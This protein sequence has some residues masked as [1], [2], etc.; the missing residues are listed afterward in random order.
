RRSPVAGDMPEP[1]MDAVFD[2]VS[3]TVA[4]VAK[5][6]E[7]YGRHFGFRLARRGSAGEG[8]DVDALTGFKDSHL[9]AAFVTNG[10]LTLEFLQFTSPRGRLTCAPMNDVGCP[11][12]GFIVKDVRA[13][14]ERLQAQGIEFA[15]PPVVSARRGASLMMRDPDGIYIELREGPAIAN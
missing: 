6:I 3:L 2:H 10:T 8:P 5:S 4:N 15:G 7:F 9:D 1:Q 14:Y 12:L 13:E 11:H